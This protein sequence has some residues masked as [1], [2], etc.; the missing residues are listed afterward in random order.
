MSEL[1]PGQIVEKETSIANEYSISA[2]RDAFGV[3]VC[4]YDFE[5]TQNMAVVSMVAYR[6]AFCGSADFILSDPSIAH[7]FACICMTVRSKCPLMQQNLGLS[8]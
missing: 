2:P 5:V 8:Q 6:H 3:D 4:L 1:K 7:I